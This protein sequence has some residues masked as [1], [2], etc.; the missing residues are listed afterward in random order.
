MQAV[1]NTSTRGRQEKPMIPKG[2]AVFFCVLNGV[3]PRSRAREA[4]KRGEGGQAEERERRALDETPL[5]DAN[6]FRS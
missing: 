4:M 3:E 6:F 1:P 2:S 5:G